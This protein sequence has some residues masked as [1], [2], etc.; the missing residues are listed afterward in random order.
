M[1]GTSSAAAA[2]PA[3]G[4]VR[5]TDW[6]IIG[7]SV[8]RHAWC[9]RLLCYP[10]ALAD[11][12]RPPSGL[13]SALGPAVR[14]SPCGRGT[15]AWSRLASQPVGRRALRV[16]ANRLACSERSGQPQTGSLLPPTVILRRG[17]GRRDKRAVIM[18]QHNKHCPT[19]GCGAPSMSSSG[20]PAGC[21]GCRAPAVRTRPT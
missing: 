17:N 16:N 7:R 1:G 13:V 20:V 21:S 15:Q 18:C 6:D 5:V 10:A 3:W 11:P 4:G 14:F 12:T 19:Q 8:E 2:R 9:R